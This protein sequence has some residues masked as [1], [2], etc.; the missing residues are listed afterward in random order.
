MDSSVSSEAGWYE[1]YV[2]IRDIA[3]G[4]PSVANLPV[5]RAALYDDHD[6]TA[7]KAA[8]A[9]KKLESKAAEATDDLIAA[10]TKPWKYGCPQV[11]PYAMEALVRIAP[12]H[13]R[14]TEI[15]QHALTCQN[16][17]I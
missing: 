2:T 12:T 3:N 6:V 10:A 17:G 14:L 7:K 4:R 9:L 13:P 5:L 11:F 16:Y 8:V 1:R 15:C